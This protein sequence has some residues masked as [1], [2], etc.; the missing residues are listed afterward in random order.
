M[1][2]SSKAGS[3]KFTVRRQFDIAHFRFFE[4]MLYRR[5]IGSGKTWK[6]EGK[7]KAD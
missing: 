7:A 6:N 5:L 4:K 1:S 3:D 2:W